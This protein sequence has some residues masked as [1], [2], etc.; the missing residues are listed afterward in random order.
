MILDFDNGPVNDREDDI[1]DDEYSN[2]VDQLDDNHSL[3]SYQYF[4][5][6]ET[7]DHESDGESSDTDEVDVEEQGNAAT[8]DIPG[9]FLQA[10]MDEDVWIKFEGEIVDVL[11]ELDSERYGP[12]V[13]QCKGRKVM[14]ARAVKAYGAMRLAL[15]FYQLFSGQLK[16]WDFK[17]NEYDA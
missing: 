2:H 17:P 7:E 8:A 15:L 1:P 5:Q 9:A 6:G 16:K 13:C 3:T 11:L 4:E 10:T 14:Y 12:C